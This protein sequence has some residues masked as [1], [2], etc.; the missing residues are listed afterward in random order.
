MAGV[1]PR[2]W[3]A[4]L[5]DILPDFFD[6]PSGGGRVRPACP[7]D[8]GPGWAAVVDRCCV[9]IAAALEDRERFYFESIRE[10]QGALR[11]SWGGRLS[12]ASEA[13]VRSAIDLAEARSVC[14]CEICGAR[15]RRYLRGP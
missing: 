1:V 8:C 12:A 9:R 2:D 3:R 10:R 4:E 6:P 7:I 11:I 13:A 14:V 15:G 5:Q